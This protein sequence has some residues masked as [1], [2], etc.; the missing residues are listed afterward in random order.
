MLRWRA[1]VFLSVLAISS[2]LESSYN[3]AGTTDQIYIYPNEKAFSGVFSPLP[4]SISLQAVGLFTGCLIRMSRAQ[5]D[6]WEYFWSQST[7][8]VSQKDQNLQCS[9]DSLGIKCSLLCVWVI[10]FFFKLSIMGGRGK[11][12]QL[13]GLPASHPSIHPLS[14]KQKIALCVSWISV[15]WM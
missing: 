2:A 13:A 12:K 1:N 7:N 4:G 15:F 5:A 14:Y 10:F 9:H 6:K 3:C 11:R 8:K